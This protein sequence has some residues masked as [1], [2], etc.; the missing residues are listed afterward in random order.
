[1]VETRHSGMLI[2]EFRINPAAT[3]VAAPVV[4]LE[5]LPQSHWLAGSTSEP[6]AP[7]MLT[8]QA[9]TARPAVAHA[10]AGIPQDRLAAHL[11]IPLHINDA[12]IFVAP[13]PTAGGA[14]DLA[15][16]GGHEGR[17]ADNADPRSGKRQ[18]VCPGGE[19]ATPATAVPFTASALRELLTTVG[20]MFLPSA[21]GLMNDGPQLA[22]GVTEQGI[23]MPTGD[24][25]AACK[26]T[27]RKPLHIGLLTYG[28]KTP[29][30]PSSNRADVPAVQGVRSLAPK[31]TLT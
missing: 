4:A 18:L 7:V 22:A 11:A 30:T 16:I 10:T 29:P 19:A 23:A 1:V 8:D 13:L 27:A 21:V 24:V 26:A 20:A 14:G 3:K 9:S 25:G 5:D 31:G 12:R 2:G 28:I 15:N 6:V 17:C